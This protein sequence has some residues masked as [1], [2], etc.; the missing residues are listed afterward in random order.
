MVGIYQEGSM[1]NLKALCAT[2]FFGVAL[3]VGVIIALP[4]RATA[5]GKPSEQNKP[6][7]TE[8]KLETKP[9]DTQENEYRYVAQKNDSYS[10]MVRKAVQTYGIINKV[11]LSNAKIIAIE[12]NITQSAGSPLL[13]IGQ[14][15]VIKENAIKDWVAKAQKFSA[16]QEAA[17]NAYTAGV[18]FNTNAVGEVR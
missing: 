9:A 7:Q 2:T 4:G 14:K 5:E 12:T 3:M 10:Q 6:A 15:V 16:T 18:D 13:D 1:K 8:Q 11:K 17:W